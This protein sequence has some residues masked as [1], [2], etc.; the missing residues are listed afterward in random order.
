MRFT[1]APDENDV[2]VILKDI[3][4]DDM[5][6]LE[7]ANEEGFDPTESPFS[8]YY[9]YDKR[10]GFYVAE[11]FFDHAERKGKHLDYDEYRQSMTDEIIEDCIHPEITEDESQI[12]RLS[13]GILKRLQ[14][15]PEDKL[16]A[17][18][19]SHKLMSLINQHKDEENVKDDIAVCVNTIEQTLDA[20]SKW[21]ASDEI[22]TII[23]IDD[24]VKTLQKDFIEFQA[25]NVTVMLDK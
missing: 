18:Y 24:M 9:L 1:L 6:A 5:N 23:E 25:D 10:L 7:K 3:D 14:G 16:S 17:L 22:R 15:S 13:R 11:K 20:I 21:L 12:E 19:V 4:R 8:K 2:T